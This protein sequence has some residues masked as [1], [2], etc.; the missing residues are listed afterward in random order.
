VKTTSSST[1]DR[2]NITSGIVHQIYEKAINHEEE[3]N[4]NHNHENCD[5]C[6]EIMSLIKK[7]NSEE[8]NTI[9]GDDKVEKLDWINRSITIPDSIMFELNWDETTKVNIKVKNGKIVLSKL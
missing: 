3:T 6:K 7:F 9:E 4:Q 5:D 2:F 8:K 1:V